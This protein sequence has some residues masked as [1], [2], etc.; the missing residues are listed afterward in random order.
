MVNIMS[1]ESKLEKGNFDE[2]IKELCF[3]NSCRSFIFFESHKGRNLYIWIGRYPNGPSIKY[4]V[5]NR[6]LL[7]IILSS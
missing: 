5:E 2:Q 3:L 1:Q 7:I 4:Y 6:I